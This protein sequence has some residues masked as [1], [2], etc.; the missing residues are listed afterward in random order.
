MRSRL[1]IS[2]VRFMTE[3]LK[4]CG[5][6][7]DQKQDEMERRKWRIQ[8]MRDQ[9]TSRTPPPNSKELRGEHE[10]YARQTTTISPQEGC[11]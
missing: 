10:L 3:T 5:L 4:L 9:L 6:Y 8:K 2:E 7:M 1:T 11:S